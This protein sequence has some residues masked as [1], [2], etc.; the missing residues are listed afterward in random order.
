VSYPAF[1][2]KRKKGQRRE[3]G[4]Y[5]TFGWIDDPSRYA[6]HIVVGEFMGV[7]PW[8]FDQVPFEE[9]LVVIDGRLWPCYRLKSPENNHAICHNFDYRSYP[10]GE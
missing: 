8:H 4:P 7:K 6:N 1:I 10:L 9:L 5:G 3:Y 2:Q